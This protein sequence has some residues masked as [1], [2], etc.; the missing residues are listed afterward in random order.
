MN[1]HKIFD[2]SIKNIFLSFLP[3][4]QNID[5][6]CLLCETLQVSKT[7]LYTWPE[8]QLNHKQL[9]SFKQKLNERL[10]GKP[11]A[12]IIGQK[13][14]WN[15]IIKVNKNIFIP[16]ND[17]EIMIEIIMN[18]F[19]KIPYLKILDLGTGSGAIGLSLAKE[20]PHWKVIALDK[21]VAA[22]NIAQHNANINSIN[23]IKFVVSW[24][25]NSLNIIKPFDIIVS[26]PPYID[27]KDIYLDKDVSKYEPHHAIFSKKNGLY[28]IEYIIKFSYM[29]LKVG[30][31]IIIE[32]GFQQ[33]K[34]VQKLFEKYHYKNIVHY[35]DYSNKLRS[36]SAIK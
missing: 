24:W 25:F 1:K 22:I 23:N 7:F 27:K 26:N 9:D 15:L 21:S 32:H 30:G 19:S 4:L 11:I 10:K 18:N 34:K 29:Y 6:E 20:K 33:A 16:R 28:D 8:T 12:Y 35:K 36:T 13:P 3:L 14:F 5:I 17:T 31:F 2:Y